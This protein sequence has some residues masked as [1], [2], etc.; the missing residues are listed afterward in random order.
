VSITVQP[1]ADGT[2]VALT[3]TFADA[4]VRDQHVQ[5]WRY[6]LSLFGNVVAN[7]LNAGAAEIIDA[8]FA[9]WRIGDDAERAAALARI[10]APDLT[11]RDRF[12]VVDGV[13]ELVPQIGAAIRFMPDI[14]LQRSGEPRHCQ[15]H[16]LVDWK[17][18]TADGHTRAS[19][20]NLFVLGATRLITS[21]VGFWN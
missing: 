16:L 14:R 9:A 7:E 10:A 1:H 2:R 3:H 11:F 21:V 5:G 4:A 13:A 15:G 17:A 18:V 20:T 19:G 6:Q 8:W 12:S